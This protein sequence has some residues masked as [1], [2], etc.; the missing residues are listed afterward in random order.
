MCIVSCFGSK[1]LH[2]I[3]GS[4]MIIAAE[5]IKAQATQNSSVDGFNQG[6]VHMQSPLV[7]KMIIV[8][9]QLDMFDNLYAGY[10]NLAEYSWRAVPNSR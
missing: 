2:F 5:V 10:R 6:S 9:I 8:K 4:I 1:V 3:L 7:V